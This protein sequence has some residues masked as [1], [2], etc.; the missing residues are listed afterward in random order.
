MA[1]SRNFKCQRLKSPGAVTILQSLPYYGSLN[2]PTAQLTR[3]K[4]K[5]KNNKNFVKLMYALMI[6]NWNIY[7]LF[8]CVLFAHS[9]SERYRKMWYWFF[10]MKICASLFV[11]QY[12]FAS[13]FF[14]WPRLAVASLSTLASKIDYGHANMHVPLCRIIVKSVVSV[15]RLHIHILCAWQ[16][17]KIG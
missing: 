13:S 5:N 15:S 10:H 12:C 7:M 2:T 3:N 14:D 4:Y 6:S 8:T 16:G 17:I 11:H 9:D 1:I